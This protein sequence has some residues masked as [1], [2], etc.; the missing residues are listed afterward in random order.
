MSGAAEAGG[1]RRHYLFLQGPLSP[2]YRRVGRGLIAAG[3]AVTRV[4]F[5]GG[6]WLH[7]HGR[8]TTQFR[9]RRSDWAAC[10]SGM[11]DRLGV[12][13]LVL[14]GDTRPYHREAVK[15]AEA[16]GITV[17]VTELGLLRPGFLTHETGGLVTL[18]RFPDDRRRYGQSRKR[19]HRPISRDAIPDRSCSRPGR[20]FPTI[21]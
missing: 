6:D 1:G 5:C 9:G 11:F 8:E 2:L 19:L 4:N 7:W 14:H 3:H 16:R 10:V 21:S 18:S 13:D 12:T 15:Q 17:H 20:T